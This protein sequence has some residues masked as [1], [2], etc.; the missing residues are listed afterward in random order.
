MVVLGSVLLQI[1]G[2]HLLQG[3]SRTRDLGLVET[4]LGWIMPISL[5]GGSL[6]AEL[7]LGSGQR[8]L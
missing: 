8:V 2:A 1:C 4:K 7:G 5:E 3:T 6:P